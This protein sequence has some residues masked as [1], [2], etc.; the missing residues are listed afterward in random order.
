MKAA[1]HA[2]WTKLRTDPGTVW[3]LPAVVVTTV[4]VGA[5]T[6]ATTTCP[7]G[8]C[9]VD[10]ARLSLTGVQLG[11]AV[12]AILGVLTIGGE[13]GTGMVR[14]TLAAVPRR[15]GLLAAKAMV[16]ACA[17]TAAATVAVPVS[18]LAG[19][20][21]L[22]GHGSPPLSPGDPDVLRAAG[23][24]VIYLVLIALLGL[25]VATAVRNAPAAIG[26]VLGLL[27]LFPVVALAVSDPDWQRHL[28][29]IGPMTAGLSIQ[30]T[31]GLERLPIGPWPGLGVLGAWTGAALLAGGLLLQRRDA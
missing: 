6:V 16:L 14:A 21:I 15:A 20:L 5:I 29:R 30:V 19:W 9:T 3:L 17:V 27:Y 28:H 22:P 18:L 8:T 4:A 24:S 31:A 10:P 26:I 23:G 1:L 7:S 11:Q 25:G 13:Y 2:E 12:V